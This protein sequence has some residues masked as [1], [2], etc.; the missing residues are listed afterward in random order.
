MNGN[1]CDS[2]NEWIKFVGKVIMNEWQLA[3][4]VK[5]LVNGY[6]CQSNHE[7]MAIVVKAIMNQ[8]MASFVKAIFNERQDVTAKMKDEWLNL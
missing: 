8:W 5:V 6:S 4:V 7:R 1:S 3:K 2:N